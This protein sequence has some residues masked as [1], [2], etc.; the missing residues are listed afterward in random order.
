MQLTDQTVAAA[1]LSCWSGTSGA[2]LVKR[3]GV[4]ARRRYYAV[5]VS[6]LDCSAVENEE[7]QEQT[8]ATL[9]VCVVALE[10]FHHAG[11]CQ[12]C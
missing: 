9:Q 6:R 3:S 12:L 8:K 4:A 2:G 7:D 11:H 10:C 5:T 1:S